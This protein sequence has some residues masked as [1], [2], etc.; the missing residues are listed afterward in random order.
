[1]LKTLGYS[2]RLTASDENPKNTATRDTIIK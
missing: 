1:L 2:K